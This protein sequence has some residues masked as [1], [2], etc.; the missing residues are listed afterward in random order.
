ML[1]ALAQ[2]QNEDGTVTFK[3]Q[4]PQYDSRDCSVINAVIEGI[5]NNSPNILS[6]LYYFLV[7]YGAKSAPNP[8]YDSYYSNCTFNEVAL[9][10]MR[11]ALQ[12]NTK[13]MV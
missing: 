7:D 4:V 8:P 1:E 5:E 6:V 9:C 11:L 13:N 10:E 2:V 3:R 12:R